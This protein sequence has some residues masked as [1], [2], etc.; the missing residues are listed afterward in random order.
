MLEEV[1]DEIKKELK[2]RKGEALG[3][4]EGFRGEILHYAKLNQEGLID[5]MAIRD[6]SSCN[7]P[8][9]AEIGPGNIVPDFP[10]CNK[11]LNLSY[12][13]NDL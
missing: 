9:F 2:P 1:K 13:G 8:L 5:R 6:P 12:S 11:S 3:A 10:L 7:W 4:V